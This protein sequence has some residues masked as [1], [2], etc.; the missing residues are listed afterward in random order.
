MFNNTKIVLLPNKEFTLQ[1][2][3]GIYL[4]GNKQFIDVVAETK[5]VYILLGKES[6]GDSKIPEA[7]TPIMAEFQNLFPNELP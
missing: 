5:R 1:Q 6:N 7:V 3:L 2:D 4:L